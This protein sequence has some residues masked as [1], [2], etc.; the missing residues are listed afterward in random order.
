MKLP[1]AV[2]PGAEH[3]LLKGNDFASLTGSAALAE[4]SGF[5]LTAPRTRAEA[6][7]NPGAIAAVNF[8][9]RLTKEKACAV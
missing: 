8:E 7:D 1:Q 6:C 9:I 5:A 3:L 4:T 2:A